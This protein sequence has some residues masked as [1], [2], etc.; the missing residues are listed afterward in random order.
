MHSVSVIAATYN[1]S[2]FLDLPLAS[3]LR[4]TYKQFELVLVDDGSTDNTREVVDRCR[5]SLNIKYLH[6]PKGTV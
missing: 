5:G 1:K 2:H 3:Y 6:Q 4:Q